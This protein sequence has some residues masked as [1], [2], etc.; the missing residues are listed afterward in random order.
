MKLKF[1]IV[2]GTDVDYPFTVH[3]KGFIFWHSIMKFRNLTSAEN[4]IQERIEFLSKRKP[5]TIIKEY[6]EEDYIVDKLKGEV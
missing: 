3:K 2:V 1:R 5:G 6:S 4:F